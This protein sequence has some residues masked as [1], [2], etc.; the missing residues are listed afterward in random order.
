MPHIVALLAKA[1]HGKTTIA[2]HLEETYGTKTISLAGP[3]KRAAKAVM[4]FSDAQLWGTQAEKEAIDPRY[5]FS[6]RTFLQRLGTDGLRAFFGPDVHVNALLHQ[7]AE[8]GLQS[9]SRPTYVIDDVRFPN[10]VAAVVESEHHAGVCIKIVCEDAPVMAEGATHASEMG[11]DKVYPGHI[12]ATV[13]SSRKQGVGHLVKTFEWELHTN[14]KLSML[15][16]AL[17]ENRRAA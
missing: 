6:A 8:E 2:K 7:I 1:G 15:R 11:I 10:E 5:G 13:V 17:H 16:R 3:L 14:P 9:P 4:D 12:A